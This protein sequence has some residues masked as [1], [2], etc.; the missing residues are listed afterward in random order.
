M[1]LRANGADYPRSAVPYEHLKL[2]DWP[3]VV[4]P[5]E[6]FCTFMADRRRT[7]E[8]LHSLVSNL[9]RRRPSSMHLLW[10]WVGAGKTHSLLYLKY[11]AGST[12]SLMAIFTEFPKTARTYADVVRQLARALPLELVENQYLEVV[13]HPRWDDRLHPEPDF[14]RAARVLV[15]GTDEASRLAARWLVGEELSAAELRSIGLA[16]YLKDSDDGIRYVSSLVGLLGNPM[17]SSSWRLIWMIDEF[18]RLETLA[19]GARAQ[20]LSSLHSTFNACPDDFTAIISFSGK[21]ASKLPKWLTPELADRIGLERTIVLPPLSRTE[22]VGFLRDVLQHFREP[23]YRGDRD[24]PFED[25]ALEQ[26]VTWVEK[27]GELK[28]RSLMQYA[29]AV[30]EFADRQIAGGELKGI[31][32]AVVDGVLRERRPLFERSE[33]EE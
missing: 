32:C 18:Q 13:T 8:D 33:N 14:Q 31:S 12:Q 22:A 24:F 23:G 9:S 10:S 28:P 26:V 4:V 6:R 27:T 3:F 20:I 25:D 17:A 7:A 21:P 16:R 1:L 19:S 11:L 29:N 5:S 2:T 30:L 15:S